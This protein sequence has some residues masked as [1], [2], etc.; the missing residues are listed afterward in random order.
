[1]DLAEFEEVAG[2]VLTA[3]GREARHVEECMWQPMTHVS[4]DLEMVTKWWPT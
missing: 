4:G 2:S 3:L 1:M